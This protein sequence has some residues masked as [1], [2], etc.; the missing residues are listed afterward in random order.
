MPDTYQQKLAEKA[1]RYKSAW[2]LCCAILGFRD[3]MDDGCFKIDEYETFSKPDLKRFL[4][5]IE[6]DYSNVVQLVL[7]NPDRRR[8]VRSVSWFAEK[9]TEW[10]ES[11][12]PIFC[13]GNY[14]GIDEAVGP[15]RF[16]KEMETPPYG[17]LILQGYHGCCLRHPEYMLARDLSLSYNLFLDTENQIKAMQ[18]KDLRSDIFG[19]A[20]ENSI[21][22]GRLVFITCYNL[23]ESFISG[24]LLEAKMNGSLTQ[25]KS[26]NLEKIQMKP[27]RRRFHEIPHALTGESIT[28][29]FAETEIEE[30]FGD[31]KCHRDAFVHCIPGKDPDN[32]GNI[33]ELYFHDVQKPKVDR[34]VALTIKLI[35]KVWKLTH[36]S[37]TPRWLP[38]RDKDGRFVQ[39][40]LKLFPPHND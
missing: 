13:I 9:F 29:Q 33:R 23:I 39:T 6:D 16:S 36:N 32:R 40:N 4:R 30:F 26:S 31:L 7:K 38:K 12:D 14:K 21:S 37:D 18:C 2:L 10:Q 20:C 22:L 11:G 19:A 28:S 35:S 5:D 8:I 34:V 25:K 27:L 15:M 1:Y 3:E 24:L 17:E